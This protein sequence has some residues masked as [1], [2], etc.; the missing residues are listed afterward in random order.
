M[1]NY[2]DKVKELDALVNNADGIINLFIRLYEF[3]KKHK[4]NKTTDLQ[5]VNT[6]VKTNG[7]N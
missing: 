1:M 7:H 6:G 4:I 2:V 3:Y 5:S